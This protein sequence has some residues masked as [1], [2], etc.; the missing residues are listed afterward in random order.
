MACLIGSRAAKHWFHDYYREPFDWDYLTEP[1]EKI[2]GDC[3]VAEEG[4][5]AFLN[6]P[7]A[8]PELLY[9]LKVSHSFWGIHHEKTMRDIMFFQSKGI[10]LDE[11]LFK[12][13]YKYWTKIH[14][15]KKAKLNVKNEEFFTKS[16]NRKYEHDSLHEAIKYYDEPMYKKLKKDM[17]MA[18][19]DRSMFEALSFEDKCKLAREES[20]VT[21]LERFLIPKEFEIEPVVAYRRAQKLLITSMSKS[22]FPKFIVENYISLHRPDD[23]PWIELFNKGVENGTVIPTKVLETTK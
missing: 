4:L 11:D 21:A 2:K 8:P 12:S 1:G 14:G 7:I 16:V 5:L 23:H 13:L 18:L 20:Y 15:K 17:S 22:W 3:H 9:T 10:K 6:Y 19:L